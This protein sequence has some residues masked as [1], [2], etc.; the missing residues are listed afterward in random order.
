MLGTAIAMAFVKEQPRRLS[1]SVSPADESETHLVNAFSPECY[2][3]H[4]HHLWGAKIRVL[5]GELPTGKLRIRVDHEEVLEEDLARLTEDL[6]PLLVSWTEP[7]PENWI[8]LAT[9]IW[10]NEGAQKLGFLL[11]NRSNVEVWLDL[12]PLDHPVKLEI[13]I[14]MNLYDAGK[15]TLKGVKKA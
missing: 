7:E 3:T 2:V 13:E 6:D 4:A 8:F 11:P 10:E 14:L 15:R 1:F 5:E 9:E 12:E